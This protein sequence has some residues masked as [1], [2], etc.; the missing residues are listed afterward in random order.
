MKVLKVLNED[1][2]SPFQGFQFELGKEYVCDDFDESGEECSTGFYATDFNGLSYSLNKDGKKLLVFEVEVS[3]KSKEFDQFKR[4]YE[5]MTIVRQLTE[6]EIKA[7]LS[8]CSESEGYNVLESCYPVHYFKIQPTITVEEAV[9]LL[10][11]WMKV[12]ASVRASVWASVWA[13]VRNSVGASVGDSVVDSVWASVWASVWD[14]VGASVWASVRNSVGASVGDSV[15]DL[16]YAYI[17]SLFPG[18]KKWKYIEH[19]EGVNPYQSGID[20]WRSGYVPS[21]D[22]KTWR[23]HTKNGVVYEKAKEQL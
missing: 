13:S 7:G 20:L 21:F 5:K 23:L 10:E 15:E 16:I 9:A 18:I 12:R 8:A 22:G 19:E 1:M 6:D 2:T 14:S 17:S 4:R 11:A 3:G